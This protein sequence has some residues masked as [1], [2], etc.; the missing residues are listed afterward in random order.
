MGGNCP[1]EDVIRTNDGCK[2]AAEKFETTLEFCEKC[3]DST[4]PSGCFYSPDNPTLWF[5]GHTD[6]SSS[7]PENSIYGGLCRL[8]GMWYL[9]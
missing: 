8:G 9:I 5:N 2:I 4:L 7:E 6:I 1:S 3:P